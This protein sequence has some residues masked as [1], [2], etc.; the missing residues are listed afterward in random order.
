M[1]VDM[2]QVV[3]YLRDFYDFTDRILIA[4]GAGGGQFL[5][6]YRE[7][8]RILAVD[9]DP[10]ALRRLGEAVTAKGLNDRT[11]VVRADFSEITSP[12]EV[13]AETDTRQI[14]AFSPTWTASA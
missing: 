11:E 4:V 13:V 6:V 8:R 10:E 9:S 3:E 7:A 14:A 12:A 2:R 1:T 5:D